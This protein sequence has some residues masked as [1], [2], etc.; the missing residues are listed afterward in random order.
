MKCILHV[1]IIQTSSRYQFCFIDPNFLFVL[2]LS[3]LIS[4]LQFDCFSFCPSTLPAND[5]QRHVHE[6]LQTTG[7]VQP[8]RSLLGSTFSSE[9]IKKNVMTVKFGEISELLYSYNVVSV[10]IHFRPQ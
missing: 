5:I 7:F 8:G 2:G 6:E 10:T 4:S 9:I 1:E 3:I